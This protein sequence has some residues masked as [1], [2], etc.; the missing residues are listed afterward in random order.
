MNSNYEATNTREI[1][2]N[3][4]DTKHDSSYYEPFVT[5]Q[6]TSDEGNQGMFSMI[7]IFVP[8]FNYLFVLIFFLE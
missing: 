1:V 7:I 6:Y 5:D 3:A 4:Y 8:S 2:G